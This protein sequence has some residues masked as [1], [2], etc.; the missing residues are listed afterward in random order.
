MSWLINRHLP[1]F[2]GST[3]LRKNF[4]GATRVEKKSRL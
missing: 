1:Y 2:A 3:A 4:L